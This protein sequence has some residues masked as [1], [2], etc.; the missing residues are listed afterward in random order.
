MSRSS[1]PGTQYEYSGGACAGGAV[2]EA[3]EVISKFSRFHRTLDHSDG[4]GSSSGDEPLRAGAEAQLAIG[5]AQDWQDHSRFALLD[6]D[7]T[8]C[9]GF[10]L[11]PWCRFLVEER[12]L[13]KAAAIAVEELFLCYGNHELSHDD[14]CERTA[15]FYAHG[16]AGAVAEDVAEAAERFLRTPAGATYSFVAP[17]LSEFESRRIAVAVISGAP[18]VILREH[19]RNLPIGRVFGMEVPIDRQGRYTGTVAENFGL[20]AQKLRAVNSLPRSAKIVLA[21]G[22]SA[23]DLPL[24][25][26][27][28]IRILMDRNLAVFPESVRESLIQS[29]PSTLWPMVVDLMDAGG[30]EAWTISER[31]SRKALDRDNWRCYSQGAGMVLQPLAGTEGS[32]YRRLGSEHSSTGLPTGEIRRGQVPSEG[33]TR[34]LTDRSEN[35]G[36][37][38]E[39]VLALQRTLSG[40]TAVWPLLGEEQDRPELRDDL[41]ASRRHRSL[42]RLLRQSLDQCRTPRQGIG[43]RQEDCHGMATTA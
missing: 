41:P 4:G 13:P 35:P 39:K 6:W 43:A 20:A 21:V 37:P 22:N 8:L 9:P 42:F 36:R 31:L 33:R 40:R 24:L 19:A 14:L 12:L 26:A 18:G 34:Q 30:E 1:T 10:T 11:L 25:Q 28:E 7:G 27:A 38:E 15:T 2:H 5:N 16:L 23:S 17:L 29:T 3:T 32:P